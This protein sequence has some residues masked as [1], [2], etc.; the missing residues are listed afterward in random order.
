[1]FEKWFFVVVTDTNKFIFVQVETLKNKNLLLGD[2]PS[3]Q[4]EY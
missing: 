3:Y 2:T 1:M 4:T